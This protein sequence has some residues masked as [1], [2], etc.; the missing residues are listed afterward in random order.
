M[1]L[2]SSHG[3]PRFI[4]EFK[5][6]I[7]DFR[8]SYFSKYKL[9]SSPYQSYLE[10]YCISG[11]LSIVAKWFENG[12][13]LSTEE[14]LIFLMVISVRSGMVPFAECESKEIPPDLPEEYKR[15]LKQIPL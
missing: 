8:K 3:D 10:E 2:F 13:G 1:V 7:M 4:S 12:N 14:M 5:E 9:P 11:L 15:I 6:N